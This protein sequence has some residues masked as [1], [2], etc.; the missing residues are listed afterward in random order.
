MLFVKWRCSQYSANCCFKFLQL[1]NA[2]ASIKTDGAIFSGKLA[3]S[4]SESSSYSPNLGL[5]LK[6][7]M[8]HLVS[9]DLAYVS[10]FKII[11]HSFES[12][13]R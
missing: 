4:G 10:H 13:L 12:T 3:V 5:R 6:A 1:G 11:V 9:R 2:F 8:A 7:S